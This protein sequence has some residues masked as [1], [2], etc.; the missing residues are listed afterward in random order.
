MSA[1]FARLA[2]PTRLVVLHGA[3][4]YFSSTV[5]W[6]AICPRADQHWT[7]ASGVAMTPSLGRR[8]AESSD[9][10]SPLLSD[11]REP[12]ETGDQPKGWRFYLLLL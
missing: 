7:S 3:S 5:D 10:R 11:G 1:R 9:E 4:A 2:A 8:V 12:P 6:P